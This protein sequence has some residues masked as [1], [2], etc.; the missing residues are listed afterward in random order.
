MHGNYVQQ[1]LGAKL[2]TLRHRIKDKPTQRKIAEAIG[3]SLTTFNNWETATTNPKVH[4]LKKLI[5]LYLHKEAFTKGKELEEARQLWHEAEVRASFDEEW[6]NKLLLEQLEQGNCAKSTIAQEKL[7][8]PAQAVSTVKEKRPSVSLCEALPTTLTVSI[9]QQP[10]TIRPKCIALTAQDK[11]GGLFI[12]VRQEAPVQGDWHRRYL[13]EITSSAIRDLRRQML[14]HAA[15]I[16]LELHELPSAVDTLSHGYVQEGIELERQP[17]P[18][19]LDMYDKT[20]G[21]LIILGAAGSGKTFLLLELADALLKRARQ[22]EKHPIPFILNLSSWALGR[23]RLPLKQ[24]IINELSNKY[25]ITSEISKALIANNQLLPLL[26]GLD[27]AARDSCAACI[28]AINSFHHDHSLLLIVVCSRSNEYL[29]PSEADPLAKLGHKCN[30]DSSTTFPRNIEKIQ[31]LPPKRKLS[32]RGAVEV[33]P[34]VME[35]IERYLTDMND[36]K[37]YI[38]KVRTAIYEDAQLRELVSTP[39]MLSI[40]TTL[41]YHQRPIDELLRQT[42]ERRCRCLACIAGIVVIF[43]KVLD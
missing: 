2:V 31:Y 43:H 17:V 7:D 40:L 8:L 13:L 11:I 30:D 24:W 27:E 23:S 35:Q 20:A 36:E 39:L 41:A 26:D 42:P 19:I 22:D 15:Y 16:K 4:N 25:Q 28:D 38:E 18:S 34:L 21:A 14:R 32:L 9:L 3:V 37:K 1:T 10:A 29:E 6:F 5:D 12:E 33:Q